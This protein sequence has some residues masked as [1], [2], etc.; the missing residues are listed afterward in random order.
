MI[1]FTGLPKFISNSIS[2]LA[3]IAA[4]LVL[5]NFAVAEFWLYE[6]VGLAPNS[7]QLSDIVLF[8][9]VIAFFVPISIFY[10]N[11]LQAA[12]LAPQQMSKNNQWR[13][14]N[15]E[16]PMEPSSQVKVEAQS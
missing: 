11:R 15:G 10:F 5:A 4:S 8:A 12:F 6:M 7:Y 13:T 9:S 16:L 2:V 14:E 3:I 1:E